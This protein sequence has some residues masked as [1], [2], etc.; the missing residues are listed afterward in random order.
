[1][2]KSTINRHIDI[3]TMYHQLKHQK[4]HHPSDPLNSNNRTYAPRTN[5]QEKPTTGGFTEET[6]NPIRRPQTTNENTVPS[7][8]PI[9]RSHR[10]RSQRLMHKK[11]K[12]MTQSI[13]TSDEDSKDRVESSSKNLSNPENKDYLTSIYIY[14]YTHTHTHTHTHTY[15]Y[16]YIYICIYIYIY[17]Y[18]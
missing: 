11:V 13:I 18:I 8:E 6:A 3:P 16:I 14:I 7:S 15:I 1:M 5:E 17:I 12:H 4:Q 9:R 10:L 2:D